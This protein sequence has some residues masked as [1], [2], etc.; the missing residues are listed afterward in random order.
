MKAEKIEVVELEKGKL[1]QL[2]ERAKERLLEEDFVILGKLVHAYLYLLQLIEY[3]NYSLAHLRK[4]IFGSKSEK[5]STVFK[6]QPAESAAAPPAKGEAAPP[7]KKPKGHGRNGADAYESAEKIEVPHPSLKPG[8]PC[9]ECP[10]G[11]VYLVEPGILIRVVGQAPLNATRYDLEKLRCNACEKTFQAPPPPGVGY[12]KYD[13]TV[14]SM[15]AL[16][17]YGSGVPFYRLEG[18]ERN[19]GVPMPASTQWDIVAGAVPLVQPAHQELIRQAAQGQVVH[20]DDTGMT[21]LEFGQK[22]RDGTKEESPDRKGTFTSGVIS[23]NGEHQIALYFTG[24]RHAGENLEQLL[25]QRATDLPPP[26]QM[27][28]ALSRNVPKEFETILANCLGHLR[29]QFVDVAESF[30]EECLH[31]LNTLKAV[32]I[33]D[34]IAKEQG[35]SDEERLAFHQVNSGKLMDDLKEWADNLFNKKLVEPN[36]GLGAALNYLLAHWEPLTLFLRQ[37]GAPLDNNV[38]ERSLKKAILNRKN[39]M[40]YKTQNGA[41]VGDMYMSLIYTAVL[42]KAN[43]YDYLNEL[44]RHHKELAENPQDWMPWNYRDTLAR[45]QTGSSG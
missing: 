27:C 15:I 3:T 23:V 14:A 39:S 34:A 43:P 40:F 37:A 30:P 38:V 33:N 41:R 18:L 12:A 8:D 42:A 4:L 19:L 1:D 35:M 24:H 29:R 16:L 44:Q 20:N 31:L 10:K 13:E 45:M 21:I 22:K 17:K 9:P 25:K 28:D 7:K 26:I 6:G 5:T 32:Y 36:S 2:L 11:K